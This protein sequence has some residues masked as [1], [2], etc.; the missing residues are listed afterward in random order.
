MP[1][2][3][4]DHHPPSTAVPPAEGQTLHT[5]QDSGM[6]LPVDFADTIAPTDA[7][8]PAAQPSAQTIAGYEILGELGRGGMGVVYKARQQGL[9][10][11]KGQGAPRI[12][13]RLAAHHLVARSVKHGPRL[14]AF[15]HGACQSRDVRA[16]PRRQRS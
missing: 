8:A 13:G 7:A 6:P 1:A 3:R 16:W 9:G 4:E 2:P 5:Q 15:T 12:T 14:S 11:G 10:R